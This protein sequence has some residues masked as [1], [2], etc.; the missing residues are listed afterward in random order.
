MFTILSL[1]L[2][3]VVPLALVWGIWRW[4]RRVQRPGLR[5][6]VRSAVLAS[7]VTPTIVG[8]PGLH[9]ALPMPAAWVL[10]CGLTGM[11]SEDR[12]GDIR[13]GGIP[14]LVGFGVIWAMGLVAGFFRGK[15]GV[16]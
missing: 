10:V 14:L 3:F 7:A 11:G 6:A 13:L 12:W 4:T 9:G 5:W 16:S 15:G 1:L 8:V 2:I